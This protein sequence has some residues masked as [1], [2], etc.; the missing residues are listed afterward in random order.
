MEIEKITAREL[1]WIYQRPMST[2][3]RL[4]AK[5]KSRTVIKDMFDELKLA[6]DEDEFVQIMKAQQVGNPRFR[7][8]PAF[9]REN[10][11]KRR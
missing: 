3:Y 2:I 8:D 10:R 5:C 11:S 6:V 9:Q 1:H 7:E 4:M